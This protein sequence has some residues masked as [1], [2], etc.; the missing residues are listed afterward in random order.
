MSLFPLFAIMFGVIVFDTVVILYLYA[1]YK[2][3]KYEA[4]LNRTPF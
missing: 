4:F 2:N 1:K 3:A